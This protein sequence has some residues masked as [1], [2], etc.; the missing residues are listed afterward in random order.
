MKFNKLSPEEAA[1]IV[2]KHTEPP[3]SGKYDNF[4]KEG[5]YVCRKCGTP[6]YD[7]SRKFD[8]H[9]GWPSFD[10]EIKGAVRKVPDADGVRTEIECETCGAHLGHVFVNEHFTDTNTRFCVNSTSLKFIPK[11]GN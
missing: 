3:F 4:F 6:L 11:D 8:A 1:V 5:V 7:S 2:G 9:C 10:Q